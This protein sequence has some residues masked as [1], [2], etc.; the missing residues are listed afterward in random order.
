MHQDAPYLLRL[1]AKGIPVS[2][3]VKMP[4]GQTENALDDAPQSSDR[5]AQRHYDLQ[6]AD[7]VMSQIEPVYA[8]PAEKNPQ[9]TSG[10]SVSR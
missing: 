7:P 2:I 3:V 6:N 9:Q 5:G 8:D 4:P 10:H 1:F